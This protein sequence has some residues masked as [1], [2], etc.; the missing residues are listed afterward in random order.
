MAGVIC[1]STG[2]QTVQYS[3]MTSNPLF[4]KVYDLD[5]AACFEDEMTNKEQ[6]IYNGK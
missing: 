2:Q 4:Y 5:E 1:R 6:V 3:M